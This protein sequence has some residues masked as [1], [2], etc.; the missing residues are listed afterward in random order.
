MYLY[1]K[2][3]YFFFNKIQA[4][5]RMHMIRK[6]KS[7]FPSRRGNTPSTTLPIMLCNLFSSHWLSSK[8][9]SLLGLV[10]LYR[11]QPWLMSMA[12]ALDVVGLGLKEL[13][14]TRSTGSCQ[15]YSIQTTKF[16]ILGNWSLNSTVIA[17]CKA[18]NLMISEGLF[19]HSLNYKHCSC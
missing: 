11:H 4:E 7:L 5:F 9:F 6:K 17:K 19:L 18:L 16:Y 8:W 1:F 14:L 15:K 3:R 13:F 2:L 10:W 12:R